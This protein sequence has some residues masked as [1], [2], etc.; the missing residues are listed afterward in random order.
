ML[1][2]WW[3][4][5]IVILK[6]GIVNLGSLSIAYGITTRRKTLRAS[7]LSLGLNYYLDRILCLGDNLKT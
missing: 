4:M 6:G 5:E 1:V 3:L 2:V 7:W